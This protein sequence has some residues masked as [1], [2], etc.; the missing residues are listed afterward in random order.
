MLIASK[1]KQNPIIWFSDAESVCLRVLLLLL[2]L[3]IFE[4]IDVLCRSFCWCSKRMLHS[5]QSAQVH[6]LLQCCPMSND[7]CVTAGLFVCCLSYVLNVS[8]VWQSVW[9]FIWKYF[10]GV[11]WRSIRDARI[12][13]FTQFH[14]EREIARERGKSD[15]LHFFSVGYIFHEINECNEWFN[16]Y[17]MCAFNDMNIFS[18]NFDPPTSVWMCI[19]FSCSSVCLRACFFSVRLT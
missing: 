7:E 16:I 9:M 8:Y 19:F 2:L 13:L 3:T 14:D 6:I 1:S 18:I 15:I 10:N 11:Y 17:C 12:H 5:A 4:S